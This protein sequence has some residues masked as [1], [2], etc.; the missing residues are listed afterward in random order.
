MGSVIRCYYCTDRS[1]FSLLFYWSV[2]SGQSRFDTGWNQDSDKTTSNFSELCDIPSD[3][4]LFVVIFSNF[5]FCACL[6]QWYFARRPTGPVLGSTTH[7]SAHGPPIE[8]QHRRGKTLVLLYAIFC[9]RFC[10]S[11]C[12]P[13]WSNLLILYISECVWWCIAWT[14]AQRLERLTGVWLAHGWSPLGWSRLNPVKSC[15]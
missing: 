13:V 10:C 11:R 8:P 2:C 1:P 14:P 7:K 5:L 15:L 3:L 6:F 4:C 9:L 12:F